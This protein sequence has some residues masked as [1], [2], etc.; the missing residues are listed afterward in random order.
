MKIFLDTANIDEIREAYSWGILDG[1]TTNPS[2]VAREGKDFLDVVRQICAIVPGPVSAEVVSTTSDEMIR[3]GREIMRKV[4]APNVVIKIPMIREG[5]RAIKA[6]SSEG[7]RVNV[8][9]IFS[10]P[11]ALLAAKAGAAYVSPFIGRLDDI[12]HVGMDIVKDIRAIF[13]N[14]DFP[15]EILA[16][17]I[18]NP[19]HV[20]DAAK[21]G[22]D[23]ATMPFSVLD[24]IIKHPLTDIGLQ[25]FLKDWEKLPQQMRKG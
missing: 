25:K 9:L 4:G 10:A 8:T 19:L 3:E 12:S 24:A 17:S 21:F 16:A 11:Q 22:A 18:R 20:V 5:L 23:V 2:L 15:C 6:L 13:D 1:V 14:Y 7:L